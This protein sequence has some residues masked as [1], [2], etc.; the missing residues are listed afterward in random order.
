MLYTIYMWT[1]IIVAVLFFGILGVIFSLLIPV[2]RLRPVYMLISMGWGRTIVFLSRTKV[3]FTGKEKVDPQVPY[4]YISNHQ[5]YFDVISLFA[6]LPHPIRFVAKKELL[7]LPVFGQALWS[8]GHVI[9]DRG[10]SEKARKSMEKAV[11]KIR[12]GIPILVFA[13]GT[14]STD[15]RLGEFK[16]G[17]FF[18][19]IDSQVPLVP[20]SV[21]GTAPIMPKG[22]YR[23]KKSEVSIAIGEPVPTE[24]LDRDDM[25][26][27]MKRV[28]AEMVRNF[29]PGSPEYEA[30][31]DD[32]VLQKTGEEKST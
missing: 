10:K 1:V 16:K 30:N 2:A 7:Y 31:K 13:E 8:L 18:M 11:Q 15:H 3:R 24:G 14:R 5:S 23:F 4:V 12:R 21:A 26:W 20:V 17:G 19:G 32:P 22:G 25:D 9:V 27:L 6:Y 29:P 28:R